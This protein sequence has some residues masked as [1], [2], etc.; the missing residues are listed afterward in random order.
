MIHTLRRI[1]SR[2]LGSFSSEER[3][4]ELAEELENNIRLLTE[5]NICRG[6]PPQEA[7]RLARLEFGSV[8]SVKE[9]YRDQRGF[10]AFNGIGQDLRYALRGIRKSPG[11]AAITILLLA[12]GIGANATLFSIVNAVLLRP[13]P[14]PESDRLVWVGATRADLPFSSA[15]P[16][17]ASYHDFLEWRTQQTV[18]ESIGA[19]QP[20]GGSPGAFLIDGQPVRMEIQRMSADAFAALKVA[21]AMGRVFN[22]EE[23]RRGGTPSVVLSYQTWQERFGGAPVV[24]KTVSMNSVVHTILGVMPPGFSFPYK[25]VEAWLPAGTDAG[26]AARHAQSRS[27]RAAQAGRDRRTGQSGDGGHRRAARTGL[28]GCQQGLEGPRRADD[29]R[30]DRRYGTAAVDS[31]WRRLRGAP[32]R[33]RQ[34]R[35]H[36]A[37]ARLG[38]A[39]GDEREGGARRQPWTDSASAR[40]RKPDAVFRR[41]RD[42][43]AARQDRAGGVRRARRQRHSALRGNSSRRQRVRLHRGPGGRDGDCLRSRA[44]MD[45]QPDAAA[46]IAASGR[47]RQQRRGRAYAT[48]ADRRGSG[49]D[50]AAAHGRRPAAP[51]LPAASRGG[52]G[53]QR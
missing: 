37:G 3:D 39:A 24:G 48:G 53:I 1:W 11:F 47:T 36:P 2:M 9:S 32:H 45:E 29:E 31:V 43:A 14:Y 8:E 33:L 30:R 44:G 12:L 18:F 22:N 34:R 35:Q 7:Y 21:P 16:G 50:R 42:G 25:G 40:R 49:A 13:L 38:S 19:Y 28:P 20:T 46:R 41:R 5:A 23:D 26:A 4:R 51:Q 52:A 15:N 17:G 6:Y 10:P 27:D